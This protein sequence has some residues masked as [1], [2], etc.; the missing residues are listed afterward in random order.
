MERI[1]ATNPEYQP[2]RV[3]G[4]VRAPTLEKPSPWHQFTRLLNKWYLH[5]IQNRWLEACPDR[6]PQFFVRAL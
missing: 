5:C 4:A 6:F 1:G 3:N 2:L